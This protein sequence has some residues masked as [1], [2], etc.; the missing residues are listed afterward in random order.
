MLH[1]FLS[2][3]GTFPAGYSRAGMQQAQQ[4][5]LTNEA[6][7]HQRPPIVVRAIEV[8]EVVDLVHVCLAGTVPLHKRAPAGSGRV[9]W[10]ACCALPAVVLAP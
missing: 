5:W 1:A 6:Q 3:T 9:R 4:G 7:G 2:S 8:G 10:A